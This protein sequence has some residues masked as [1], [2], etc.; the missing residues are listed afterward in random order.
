MLANTLY[1]RNLIFP[2]FFKLKVEMEK[3]PAVVD[4]NFLINNS[5]KI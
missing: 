3:N 1:I 2:M 4:Y 5:F